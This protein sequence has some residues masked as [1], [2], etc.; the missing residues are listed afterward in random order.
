MQT[1]GCIK[2]ENSQLLF[3]SQS[4][5]LPLLFH[6]QI[7]GHIS[8]CSGGKF[9]IPHLCFFIFI[10]LVGLNEMKGFSDGHLNNCEIMDPWACPRSPA[11][12]VR[13]ASPSCRMR[14]IPGRRV[15]APGGSV[16]HPGS[17]DGKADLFPCFAASCSADSERPC[18]FSQS[19]RAAKDHATCTKGASWA[20]HREHSPCAPS[21]L[22]GVRR[23]RT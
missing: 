21:S 2:F 15:W 13:S 22:S 5:V 18:W 4:S 20:A 16:V 1:F 19:G 12:W 6:F 11:I 7:T 8:S 14:G 3:F 23:A 17:R 10:C 9:I